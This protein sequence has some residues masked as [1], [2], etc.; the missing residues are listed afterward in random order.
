[1]GKFRKQWIVNILRMQAIIVCALFLIC[2]VTPLAVIAGYVDGVNRTTLR[3]MDESMRESLRYAQQTIRFLAQSEGVAAHAAVYADASRSTEARQEA[4]LGLRWHLLSTEYNNPEMEVVAFITPGTILT[5]LSVSETVYDLSH[6]NRTLNEMLARDA[7]AA[8]L[9]ERGYGDLPAESLMLERVDE[10]TFLAALLDYEDIYPDEDGVFALSEAGDLIVADGDAAL[11][12]YVAGDLERLFEAEDFGVRGYG[13]GLLKS[14]HAVDGRLYFCSEYCALESGMRYI[15]MQEMDSALRIV[16]AAAL[17]CAA[18]CALME[19][20]MLILLSALTRRVMTPF[21]RLSETA[22]QM[23]EG[24]EG[25]R[26]INR[27]MHSMRRRRTILTRVVGVYALTLVPILAILPVSVTLLGDAVAV[28]A[29]EAYVDSVRQTA[30]MISNRIELNRRQSRALTV[31]SGLHDLLMETG[32]EKRSARDAELERLLLSH[33]MF[34]RGIRGAVLYDCDGAVIA[35]SRGYDGYGALDDEVIKSLSA[36]YRFSAMQTDP[37]GSDDTVMI[38]AIRSTK[39]QG[40]FRLFETMGYLLVE[41]EPVMD[42]EVAQDDDSYFYLYSD[43]AW[44]FVETPDYLPFRKALEG[45]AQG[46]LIDLDRAVD[47]RV[48]R[49]DRTMLLGEPYLPGFAQDGDANQMLVVSARVG[50][51]EF[52]LIGA[53]SMLPISEVGRLLPML[54]IFALCAFAAAM[55]L[56]AMLFARKLVRRVRDV[57]RYLESVGLDRC[58]LPESLETDDEIG[59]L[60]RSMRDSF[61]RINGLRQAI[62]AEQANKN[63]M[64]ARKREAE[65]IALQSQMDSHLICN[66]FATMKLLLHEGE[67]DA[68]RRVIDATSDFLRSGLVHNEYDV[69]LAREL[70]HVQAYLEIQSIRFGEK[71]VIEWEPYD[72]ELLHCRVPKYLLQ[73]VLE[74]AIKHGMRPKQCLTIRVQ[75]ERRDGELRLCVANDGY[76][77]SPEA[78]AELNLRLERREVADHIGLSNVQERIALRYGSPYGLTLASDGE[79]GW[80][81]VDIVLPAEMEEDEGCTIS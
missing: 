27:L 48:F 74:N 63:R 50:Q 67:S 24:D 49:L 41:S 26:Q 22:R 65:V 69:P 46:R 34:T 9:A 47:S 14:M 44:E 58:E 52:S 53:T 2:G 54:L 66:V 3:T 25:V 37:Y 77:L 39:V 32:D 33:G 59:A 8:Y 19:M 4:Q 36:K 42:F 38:Y 10:R 62:L 20:L 64:E 79:N 43:V 30:Q 71:L 28:E 60:A 81:R 40:T 29:R 23:A 31:D 15:Q 70:K 76:G 35:A 78:V 51:T 12:R 5:N 21:A 16:A 1:M 75:I 17:R 73:P 7:F 56:V 68:L 13:L 45:M 18:L 57:E 72:P 11:T 61:E 55:L 80:T 6:S